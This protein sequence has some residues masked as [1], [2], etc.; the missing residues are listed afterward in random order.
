MR[1]EDLAG[2]DGSEGSV[3]TITCR[4]GVDR[5]VLYRHRDLLGQVHAQAAEPPA[6]PGAGAHCLAP[7]LS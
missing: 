7:Y 4:A 1:V 6:I 5:T 3:I 2:L